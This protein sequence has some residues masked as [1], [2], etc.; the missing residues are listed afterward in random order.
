[1]YPDSQWL[2]VILSNYDYGRGAPPPVPAMA[3]AL[4]TGT[5]S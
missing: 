2:S 5:A 3:R 4:I 1:M